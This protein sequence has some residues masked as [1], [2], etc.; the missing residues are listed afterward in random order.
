MGKVIFQNSEGF[1]L[2]GILHLPKLKTT[3][4]II[5]SHGFTGSKDRQRFVALSEILA[6]EGF[7]V[8]RFDFGGCGESEDREI[9][10]KH[11]VDDLKFAI[12]YLKDRG[13]RDI[14]LLGHSLGG[15]IS[16]MCYNVHVKAIVL[17]APVTKAR[18]SLLIQKQE[19]KQELSDKGYLMYE[20][21]GRE[22]KLPQEYFDERKAINQE[23][24]LSKVKCPVLIVHG[25]MDDT[26]SIENS[27]DAMQFL[28][29]ESRLEIIEGGDHTLDAKRDE[30][31]PFSVDWFK[32]Y[33][34]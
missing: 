20:R 34:G 26:V 5:I 29:K 7:A 14:G 10:L 12:K 33:V 30:V 28:N 22:F 15:L 13:Y 17:W 18:E 2:I 27:K 8:L 9:T 4:A 32:K 6:G 23:G 3:S 21:N 31:I 19:L 24:V 11:Q 1:K 16:A 25:N